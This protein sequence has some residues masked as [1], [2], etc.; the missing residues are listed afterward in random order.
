ME[1]ISPNNSCPSNCQGKEAALDRKAAVGQPD[2][3]TRPRAKG[4][5]SLVKNLD[6]DS[7]CIAM[8]LAVLCPG[9]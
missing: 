1:N 7:F 3:Y 4:A 5:L 2:I 9:R 8:T 6:P